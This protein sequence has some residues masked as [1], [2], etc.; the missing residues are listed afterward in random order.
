[1]Y[2]TLD[3]LLDKD[4]SI[5]ED[6]T[7]SWENELR[8]DETPKLKFPLRLKEDPLKGETLEFK[9]P[10]IKEPVPRKKEV[11]KNPKLVVMGKNKTNK[12]KLF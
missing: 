1:M 12:K 2:W 7:S 4:P 8:D 6:K 3:I 10:I 11:D 5:I 9:E